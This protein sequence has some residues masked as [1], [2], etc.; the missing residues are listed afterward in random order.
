[1]DKK[2]IIAIVLSL[3]VLYIYQAFFV[4]PVVQQKPVAQQKS[5][6]VKDN[7]AAKD[8]VATAKAPHN[9]AAANVVSLQQKKGISDKD[10]A[11]ETDEF[12]AVFSTRGA[13]L[14]SFKLKKYR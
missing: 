14:K 6:T 1:M 9:T 5:A 2:S 11:I 10:V 12:T 13:A 8:V 7:A 3:T 4:K